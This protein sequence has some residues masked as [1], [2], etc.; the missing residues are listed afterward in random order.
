MITSL[1]TSIARLSLFIQAIL[2]TILTDSK[3]CK[4]YRILSNGRS[5]RLLNMGCFMLLA[6]VLQ[7]LTR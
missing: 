1:N 5:F 6:S 4:E 2:C 7:T 3:C